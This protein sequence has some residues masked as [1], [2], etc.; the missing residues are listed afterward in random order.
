MIH[1]Y[2]AREVY[3]AEADLMAR[4]PEGE[5]M[6]RAVEGLVAV[7]AARIRERRARRVVGLIGTGNNGADALYALARL[8][9]AGHATAAVL[10]E[11]VHSGA[12][13]DAVAA[14][15][16]LVSSVA[17][18]RLS[19]D[20]PDSSEMAEP[21]RAQDEPEA[22]HDL[23]DSSEMAVAEVLGDADIVLDG[24][25]GIGG[26]P[27]VPG[28]ARS[29]IEAIPADAYVI[30]VDLPTGAD[31]AGRAGDPDGVFADETVTFSVLKPVHLLP[32][33]EPRVGLLTVVDIGLELT[34]SPQAE[35]L[36]RD[37]VRDLWPVPEP[38]DHKYSRGVLGV[39]AGSADFPGAAVLTTTAAVSA[40]VGMV[41]YIGPQRATDHVV[42]AVPEVVH[43]LGQVQAWVI[44]SGLAQDISRLDDDQ[45][46]AIDQALASDVPVLIDAGGLDVLADR[47]L[48][49]RR[50]RPTIL[51][52]H[53][54]ECA[55][56]LGIERA[57]VD[58]DPVS[59][60]EQLAQRT[61]AWVLLKG[62]VTLIVGPEQDHPVIAQADGPAWLATAGSGDVLSGLIGALLAGGLS[63][64]IAGALGA[65]VH[66]VAADDANPGGPI[67][68]LDV[69]HQIP[70][71]VGR[72]L[73]R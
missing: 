59:H 51:T 57:T 21:N 19:H 35:R 34:G 25:L 38:S 56:L 53:A 50:G 22:P 30:A 58:S 64:A 8:A 9:E 69:A 18:P 32:A 20:L 5:L 36:D 43:G 14:G 12:Y 41:R 15:V 6:A 31:P 62:S 16:V 60:A 7:T 71:T 54:G 65:L 39:I 49:L 63:P 2:G 4:L 24:I 3:A 26:R 70:R 1:A 13:E 48:Q 11:K 28:F 46:V 73:R 45:S 67:R 52:P 42:T 61:G 17:R 40:G 23:P 55:R 72:L 44:G 37:D 47:G 29:W 27:E 10:T 33:T 68:A 66:G